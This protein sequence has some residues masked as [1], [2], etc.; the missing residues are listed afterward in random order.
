MEGEARHEAWERFMDQERAQLQQRA[1]GKMARVLGRPVP[2]E[3][4][5]EIDRMAADDRLKAQ[6]GLVRLMHQSG[7]KY[8]L[9]VDWLTRENRPDRIRAERATVAW[10]KGRLE[11]R[12]PSH[13]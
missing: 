10:L 3:T 7:A 2:G 13:P 6:Q 1:S 12:P 5:E 11:R 8:F 9:H 4:K